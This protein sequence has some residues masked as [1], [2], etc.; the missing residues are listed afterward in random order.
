MHSTGVR[1]RAGRRTRVLALALL[2]AITL[3]TA[4]ATAAPTA[5]AHPARLDGVERRVIQLINRHRA[6]FGLRRL[7]GAW[8]LAR[9]ADF[10]SRDMLRGRFFAHASRNGMPASRRVGRFRRATHFGETLAFLSRTAVASQASAVVSMWMASP[11][12]RAVLLAPAFRRI[13]VA[14]R[15]GLLPTGVPG[16]VFTADLQSRR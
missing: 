2:V 8:R 10:H 14:R 1:R 6:S 7:R 3:A 5:G 13:G 9:A 11:P 15:N 16:T 4:S 12:H